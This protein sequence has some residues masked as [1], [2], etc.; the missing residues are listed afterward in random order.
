MATTIELTNKDVLQMTEALIQLD[1]RP[2]E[3]KAPVPYK[4]RGGARL[5]I[6]KNIRALTPHYE[7]LMES[8]RK[9]QEDAHAEAPD[10][11]WSD[12]HPKAPAFLAAWRLEMR[13]PAPQI[14]LETI[15][16]DD[17]KAEDNGIPPTVLSF[18]QPILTGG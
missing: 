6:A 11:P 8:K 14:S 10:K 12:S 9:M 13:N 15:S 1:G 16:Y 17:L 2:Q 7:D 18:I 4:F 5:A 3:G